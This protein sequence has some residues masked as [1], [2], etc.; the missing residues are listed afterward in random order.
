MEPT[1]TLPCRLRKVR[2]GKLQ[3]LVGLSQLKNLILLVKKPLWNTMIP[4]EYLFD[5]TR[6]MKFHDD[7][8][9]FMSRVVYYFSS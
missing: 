1:V 9:R 8:F 2:T 4:N 5:S 6:M 7:S 3:L